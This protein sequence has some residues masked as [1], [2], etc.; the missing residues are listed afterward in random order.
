MW[1]HIKVSNVLL[2]YMS[3]Q[4]C[5]RASVNTSCLHHACECVCVCVC[6]CVS[7][8]VCVCVCVSVCVCAPVSMDNPGSVNWKQKAWTEPYTIPANQQSGFR[9]TD[10]RGAFDWA[11]QFK[12]LTI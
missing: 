6:V 7:E 3:L 11:P 2:F 12:I 4:T 8:S 1:A 9:S 5:W 10:G